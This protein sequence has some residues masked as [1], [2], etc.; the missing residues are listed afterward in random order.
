MFNMV[1]DGALK[2]CV[3]LFT[4]LYFVNNVH[5]SLSSKEA[6]ALNSKFE[7][8]RIG[9]ENKLVSAFVKIED[10]HDSVRTCKCHEQS[11]TS[12]GTYIL[13]FYTINAIKIKSRCF[14]TFKW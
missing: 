13:E 10:L 2:V 5:C 6:R 3:F 12:T 4:F 9:V 11:D 14:V 7:L 1:K 8:M